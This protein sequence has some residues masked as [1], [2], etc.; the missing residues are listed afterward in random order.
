VASYLLRRSGI[1]VGLVAE[2]LNWV[3]DRIYQC[4]VGNYHE[5]MAVLKSEWPNVW[6]EGCEPHPRIVCN[7]QKDGVYPGVVH[8]VA[9]SDKVGTTIL[10]AKPAHADGSSLHKNE[11][12][13]TKEYTVKVETLDHLFLPIPKESKVL[14]WLDCEGSELCALR[15]GEEFLKSVDMVNVEMTGNAP[16]GRWSTICQIDEHLATR[17]FYATHIHSH[18]VGA[19]QFDMIYVRAHLFDP[20]FCCIPAEINRF[21]RDHP[22]RGMA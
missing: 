11:R 3:A 21:F 14:L 12:E 16:S 8:P 15:G 20:K 17:G 7:L 5:E 22:E 6:I 9:I 13:E 10:Y 4:G 2:T 1:A 19:G 18:R